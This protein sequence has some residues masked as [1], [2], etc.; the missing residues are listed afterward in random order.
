LAAWTI[1]H[2]DEVHYVRSKRIIDALGALVD[3]SMESGFVQAPRE[4]WNAL[5]GRCS[6]RTGTSGRERTQKRA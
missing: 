2:L 1:G 3:L 6:G 5:A 4:N